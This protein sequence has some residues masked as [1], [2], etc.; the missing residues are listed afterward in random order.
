MNMSL[1]DIALIIF[2]M[3]VWGANFGVSKLGLQELPPLLLVGLRF[4][5]TALFL[6]PFTRLPRDKMLPV[7]LLSTTL[8][9]L[10]FALMFTGLQK[11]DASTAAI[12]VQIQVPFSALLAAIFFKDKLGWRRALGMALAIAGVVLLAGEPQ[13]SSN[14]LYLGMILTASMIWA[15]SAIQM[16]QLSD[17]D[18][19]TLNGW[20]GLFA[21]PQLLVG[22]WLLEDGQTEAIANAG[23]QGWGAVA[24]MAVAVTIIGYG[25]WMQM[26]RRYQVNQVMPF[27]LL[28]PMF[29]VLAGVIMLGESLSLL[30]LA[31]G[32]L[33]ILGVA[34]ITVRRPQQAQPV[35]PRS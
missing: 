12:A 24:F 1:R 8:G 21:A 10:H 5:L 11:V 28:A 20:M 3:A 13:T 18:T 22:S 32:A 17:L 2:V 35:A 27:T 33:T 19:L 14:I 34:I 4:A 7:L 6:V 31:G 16:K 15:V 23:W 25:I 29:G 30:K 9:L 26:L